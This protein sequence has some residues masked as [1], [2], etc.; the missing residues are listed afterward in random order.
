MKAIVVDGVKQTGKLII[1]PT[2]DGI[3]AI[4]ADVPARKQGI[5]TLQGVKVAQD[6][7][8]LP[9]GIYIR[10]GKKMIKR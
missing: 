9:P 10:D 5:Y 6:W 3:G 8:S 1:E 7:N 2:T 4:D